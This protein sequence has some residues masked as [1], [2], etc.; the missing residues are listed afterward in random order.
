MIYKF[1]GKTMTQATGGSEDLGDNAVQ[2]RPVV[3]FSNPLMS[4]VE[5]D[6]SAIHDAA[7]NGNVRTLRTLIDQG[8]CVNLS[9]LDRVTPLHAACMQGHTACVRLLTENG[10]NV[11]VTTLHWTTPL[12][13]ASARGHDAC[14]NLLLQHGA[15]PQ[16]SSLSVSC[17]HQAAPEG[18]EL[19]S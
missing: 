8:M 13:E 1:T 11:D 7:Y 12:S 17:T 19:H 5:S 14:V 9:T 10:A 3:F 15:A 16:G 6:W 2:N 18:Q 4:D